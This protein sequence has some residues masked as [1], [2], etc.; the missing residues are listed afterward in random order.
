[1]TGALLE[2]TRRASAARI[3]GQ[4]ISISVYSGLLEAGRRMPD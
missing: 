2:A 3:E 4:E 1:M